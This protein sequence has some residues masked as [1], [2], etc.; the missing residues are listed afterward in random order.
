MNLMSM[1]RTPVQLFCARRKHYLIVLLTLLFT[2]NQVVA[3]A[4]KTVRGTISDENGKALPSVSVAVKGT[5][6]G[7]LT[8][9]NGVFTITASSDAVLVI[10][11][12]GFATKEITVGDK[13]ELNISLTPSNQQ[14]EQVIVVGYGTQRRASLTGAVSSVNS[15]TLNELPVTSVAQALQGRVAGLTVINNGP[16]GTTPLV[17]IRG[18]SSISYASDPLYVIDGFPTSNLANFDTRDIESVDVLK[19][20]SAAAIYGSRATNGVIIITTRKGK[21]DGTLHVNL[22]SYIGTESPWKTIDLLNTNQYLQYERALNGAAGIAKPP[23]LEDA[24]FT[25]PIYDGATQTYAQTNTDWQDAY[26]KNGML[27]QTNLS[28]SGGNN[29]SRFYSSGGYF[30][31]DGIGEGVSFERG[32]FR[33]NSEHTISKV[34]TFG[35]NVFLSYSKQMVDNT[36][37][38]F[39]GNRTKLVN[40]IRSLPYL[41]VKD[42]TTLG[43]YRNAENS[44]DGADPTNP[45][46]DALLLFPIT[47]KTLK[48]LG[49]VYAQVNFTP[50]LYFRSTFGADYVGVSQHQFTP[51]FNDK[52]RSATVASITDQHANYTTLLFTEQFTF[53]KTFGVHHIK[54]DAIFERQG[55]DSYGETATGNQSTNIETLAGA[56]N[57]TVNSTKS[58]NVLLSYLGRVNYEYAGKYLLSAAIRRDGLSVWAPGKKYAVFPSGSIGWR[59]DQEN[60]LKNSKSISELKLRAGYGETGLNAIG[61][62]PANP[63]SILANDYPWQAVVATSGSYPFNNTFTSGNASYYSS[64][65]NPNLEWEKTKQLNIGVDLGLFK[66]KITFVAD[67]YHRQTDNLILNVPTPPSFGFAGAGVLANVASMKNDGV[68]IQAGYNKT[69]GS[70][71]WNVTGNIS[72][73]TNKV[74]QLNTPNA[75]I[76]AGGDQDF[77]GGDNMTLTV[78][79]QPIQAFYGYVVEGIFQSQDEINKSPTQV[80]GTDPAKSTAPGDLKFKDLDGDGAITSTD[81]TFIGNYLPDFTYALNFG[82]NY[83][84]F[85]F[86]FFFQGSQGNDIFNAIGVIREG[87]ARLFGSGVNVLKAW[88]PQ[89]TN[90]DIPRAISGDPNKNVRPSTRWIEDGSYLRLKNIMIGYTIPQNTLQS[91]TKG[92]VKN[93]RIYIS[94]QNLFTI[95]NYSGWDPEIG[96]K[97]NTLTGGIDY[98]QYPAARSFQFGLQAGF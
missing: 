33:I 61:I 38:P 80:P 48:V 92:A 72:F 56:T 11:S 70:F 46:E 29:V 97:N 96:S 89:N 87:M 84:N 14:L 59:L 73:I 81:R 67:Y 77:G 13:T 20:A 16:P 66:N 83:K 24:N 34:F 7:T 26:F 40:V 60:F 31:D 32:N 55:T 49:T 62:F 76:G 43:G 25:Q 39:A 37:G 4:Q 82:A 17:R 21:R 2:V 98:G 18:I 6:K 28:V 42:P 22:D 90:T 79:G 68:D 9:E 94:S 54:A 74:M 88:T 75:S 5:S 78:A 69:Q 45:V 93:F 63:G 58:E 91:L 52:G 71:T 30:K 53:D 41:P 23:R 8:N 65:A 12:V 3:F 86:S 57:T 27:T 35:E 95:T 44:F 47:Q 19:D 10:S 50:W 64:L 51:I 15:K 85:D 1:N 36:A